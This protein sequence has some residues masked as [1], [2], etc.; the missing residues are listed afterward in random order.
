MKS[1]FTLCLLFVAGTSLFAQLE[2]DHPIQLTGNGANAK[3]SGIQD[4]TDAQ[5]AMSVQSLQKG[6]FIFSTSTGSGNAFNLSLSPPITSYQKGM[7]FNFISNQSIT[8]A[9]TLNINNLGTVSIKKN[10]N[11]DLDGCEIQNGQAVTVVYDGTNFQMTSTPYPGILPTTANAGP[12]QTNAPNPATLAANA[13]TNGTGAW[14]VVT[15]SGGSFSDLFSPTST[16]SGQLGSSYVLRWT[17]TSQC[18]TSTSDVHISIANYTPGS[19][20]FTSLGG[21]TNFTVPAGVSSVTIECWGAQGGTGNGSQPGG[22]GG[23]AK[24]TLSVQSGSTLYVYVGGQ[25]GTNGGGTGSTTGGYGGGESDVRQGGTAYANWVIVAGGGGGGSYGGGAAG[26]AGGGGSSCANGVG[27]AGGTSQSP[28]YGAPGGPGTCTSGGTGGSSYGG[29]TGGGG[30][31]GLTS[32]GTGSGGG[33]YGNTA[34]TGTQGVGGDRGVNTGYS[35]NSGC[36]GGGGYYGGGG[37]SD[38]QCA[39]GSGGGGSSWASNAMTNLSFSGGTQSGN[40]KVTITW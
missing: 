20:T 32:G 10:F 37:S 12:D 36:G 2:I 38:G 19:Q 30:G 35:C 9:S 4:V 39:A 7:V 5:D 22:L 14:S 3:I 18:G 11:H 34:G 16:F 31:G 24:G 17:I 27:G 33:G 15:G 40:G 8:G 25:N 26:G 21:P 29:W 6:G 13:P 23:Y 1:F 28:Q